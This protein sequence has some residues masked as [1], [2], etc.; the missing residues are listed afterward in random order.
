MERFSR[1]SSAIVLDPLLQ[2]KKSEKAVVQ[3]KVKTLAI[4]AS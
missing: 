3:E 1:F 2:H 4:I